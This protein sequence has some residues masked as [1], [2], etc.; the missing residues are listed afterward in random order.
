MALAILMTVNSC[1]K[2]A[3]LFCIKGNGTSVTRNVQ[4][5]SFNSMDLETSAIVYLKEGEQ[6][7]TISGDE[8][9]VESILESSTL[10]GEQ[11]NI[12]NNRCVK[13]NKNE[14]TVIT[15]TL[16]YVSKLNLSG[17]G[18]IQMLEYFYNVNNLYANLGGSG[19]MILLLDTIVNLNSSIS[20]SGNLDVACSYSESNNLTISGSGKV[21]MKGTGKN[22]D[23]RISGSGKVNAFNFD[24][25]E[26]KIDVSGS[27]NAMVSVLE[28]LNVNIS[29]SG[30]IQYTGSPSI[31]AN[32]SGS[33]SL[34]NAN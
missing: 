25:K 14:V 15:I 13:G 29:G 10:E 19:D 26:A 24:C 7:V 23:I 30:K 11:W 16:P 21:Y 17:S 2:E 31:D 6:N 8:V 5:G 12:K 9:I 28:Y 22:E 3:H 20:G 32:I 1:K 18:S 4:L 34:E 27:G 33:G